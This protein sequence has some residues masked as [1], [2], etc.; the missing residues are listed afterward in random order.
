MAKEGRGRNGERRWQG[1]LSEQ[2][3]WEEMQGGCLAAGKGGILGKI[4]PHHAQVACSLCSEW[5]TWR[6]GWKKA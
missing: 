6:Q 3:Y 5:R 4:D 2:R 1:G